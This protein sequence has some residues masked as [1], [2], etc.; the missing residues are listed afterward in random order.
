[1]GAVFI[2]YRRG[3][4][5]G[6]GQTPG[7]QPEELLGKES[8]VMDVDSIA[9]GRD[10]RELLRERLCSCDVQLVVIGPGGLDRNGGAAIHLVFKAPPGY[11]V[12]PR[13]WSAH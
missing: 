2:S 13:G 3:D 10:F 9:L 6:P 1:M 12:R 8:A 11:R 4:T 7:E 5:E